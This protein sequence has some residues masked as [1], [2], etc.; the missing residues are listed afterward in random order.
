MR[1]WTPFM[2]I[3]QVFSR[4]KLLL[5]RTGRFIYWDFEVFPQTRQNIGNGCMWSLPAVAPWHLNYAN[6]SQLPMSTG[7][8]GCKDPRIYCS[9]GSWEYG[10][11]NRR[12]YFPGQAG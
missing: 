1:Q 7:V 8:S 11:C 9:T 5:N 10:P 12:R 2:P 4:L 6:A 3:T